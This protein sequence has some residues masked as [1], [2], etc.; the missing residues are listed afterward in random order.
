MGSWFEDLEE[1]SDRIEEMLESPDIEELEKMKVPDLWYADDIHEIENPLLRAKEILAVE[2]IDEQEPNLEAQLEAGE[3]TENQFLN[4]YQYGVRP[5]KSKLATRTALESVGLS[6]DHLGDIS[7]DWEML[8]GGDLEL[9]EQKEQLKKSIDS[10]GPDVSKELADRM[11]EEGKISKDTHSMIS[12]QVR[13]N[14]K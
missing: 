7:E 11:L 12:R 10:M 13:L 2:E 9:M 3:I 14:R 1:W 6:Y 4:E 5:Q 8:A